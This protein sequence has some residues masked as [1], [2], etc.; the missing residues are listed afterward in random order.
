MSTI[1]LS[2][3]SGYADRTRDYKVVCNSQVIGKISNGETR[4]FDVSE[5][6]HELYLKIDWCR[7]NKVLVDVVPGTQVEVHGGSSLRGMKLLGIFFLPIFLPHKYLWLR[8]AGGSL[9]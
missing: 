9:V 7:S 2:R 3:D 8:C 4:V 6:K 1:R 5:G